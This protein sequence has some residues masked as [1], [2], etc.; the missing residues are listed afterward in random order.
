MHRSIMM[1]RRIV[2]VMR[3]WSIRLM[4]LDQR[5]HA[6][7]RPERGSSHH[8]HAQRHAQQQQNTS[9]KWDQKF[10]KT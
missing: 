1:R 10:H 4:H 6:V 7:A 3:W 2:M 9:A 5:L 8:L